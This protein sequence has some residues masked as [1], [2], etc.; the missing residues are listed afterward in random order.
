MTAEHSHYQSKAGFTCPV[1]RIRACRL[2]LDLLISL[3]LY[4][5]D[6]NFL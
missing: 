3:Y 5:K 2:L 1:M 6:M 4:N